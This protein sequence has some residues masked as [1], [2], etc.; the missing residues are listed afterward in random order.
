MRRKRYQKGSL[1][2]RC[3]KWIGQWREE[4]VR[5]NRALGPVSSMTKSQARLALDKIL[6]SVNAQQEQ[7]PEHVTFGQFVGTVYYPLFKRKWKRST[8]TNNVSRI[9]THL[10]KP[11]GER[12][13]A[14]LNRQE[15]QS[16]LDQKATEGLSFS[17]VDH[18]R[19]DLK[20][21]FELAAGEAAIKRNPA[22]VLF[23]PKESQRRERR[24]MDIEEVRRCLSVLETRERLIVKL[25]LLA[26]MRP[27]EI[28]A[29]KWGRLVAHY[30]DIRQRVYKGDIDSPKTVTSIRK[31]ALSEGL[32]NDIEAWRSLSLNSAEDGWVFPSEKLTTPLSK[33]NCFRRRIAPRLRAVGLSWV[34][35]QVMRRTHSSL[36]NALGI[37]GKVVADQLGHTL[38]VNQNVYTQ[39]SVERRKEALDRLEGM[40]RVM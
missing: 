6:A 14:S 20:Q 40:L 22:A 31:A 8:A 38:D 16:L 25:A 12:L 11:F 21:I 35:F 33:D 15:L 30:A 27:G 37:D 7:T 9:D 4:G 18:L 24:F 36:M 28:F 2:R 34:T 23:T 29:L 5:R 10:V 3:G 13:L 1:K 17:M 39:V 26:G 19:W 32:L